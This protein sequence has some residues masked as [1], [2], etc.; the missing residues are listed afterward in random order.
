MERD[1]TPWQALADLPG[2]LVAAVQLSDGP[3]ERPANYGWATRHDR[4]VPGDG[5]M[6]L[7]NMVD[8]LR[9]IGASCP[10]TLEVFNDRAVAEFGPVGYATRLADA[11]RRTL[12]IQR[13]HMPE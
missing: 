5:A 1:R 8:T 2:D 10:L 9:G 13:S 6:A 3:A 4:L 7:T 11:T 12:A